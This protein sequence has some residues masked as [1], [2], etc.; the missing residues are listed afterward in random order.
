MR[1]IVGIDDT[2]SSRGYCTTYL[3]YRIAAD[4]RPDLAVLPYPSLVRLNPN[5]PFKTRGNAAVCLHL[6][7]E[8]PDLAFEKICAKVSELSDVRHG[9]NSGVVFLDDASKIGRAHV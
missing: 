9:A 6:E 4:L 8:D 7:A 5:I 2:D 3:A 1:C